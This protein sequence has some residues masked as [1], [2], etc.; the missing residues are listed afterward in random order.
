MATQNET[1]KKYPITA[2]LCKCNNCDSVLID[3]NP[4]IG[5]KEHEIDGTE[6][7][8]QFTGGLIEFKNV[9][10]HW[11]CPICMCDDYLVDL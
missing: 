10:P 2:N 9:D 5:A 6:L 4:Q 7:N 8:M 11:V 1:K 3:Q